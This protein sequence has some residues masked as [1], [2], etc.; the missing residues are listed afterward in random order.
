MEHHSKGKPAT[1][2]TVNG[3]QY[4]LLWTAIETESSPPSADEQAATMLCRRFGVAA[5][6]APVIA[7]LAGLGDRRA[8]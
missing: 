6:I 8:A 3:F 7:E 5:S 4:E 1:A 2:A